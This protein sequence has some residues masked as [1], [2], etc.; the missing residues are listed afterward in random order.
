MK[1]C[2]FIPARGWANG[3]RSSE[4]LGFLVLKSWPASSVLST[5]TN[6]S[7]SVG[8]TGVLKIYYRFTM[9]LK[10]DTVYKSI[11][12]VRNTFSYKE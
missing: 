10:S 11:S 1:V 8:K 4:N 12:S 5:G 9:E 2:I 7:L 3:G 6:F